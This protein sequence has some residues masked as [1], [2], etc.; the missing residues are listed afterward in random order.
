MLRKLVLLL[1]AA[2]LGLWLAAC[3]A[4]QA[5]CVQPALQNYTVPQLVYPQSGSKLAPSGLQDAFVAYPQ[6]IAG[7]FQLFGDGTTVGLPTNP[8]R[9]QCS[10]SGAAEAE[11]S[12]YKASNRSSI[13]PAEAGRFDGSGDN[14]S[15]MSVSSASGASLA[16]DRIA[17]GA[18]ARASGAL[19]RNSGDADH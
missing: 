13:A 8:P 18:F 9:V 2:P 1:C 5:G 15:I 4:S 10:C 19:S 7:A 17:T 12:G 3:S 11:A 14:A 6:P 16:T